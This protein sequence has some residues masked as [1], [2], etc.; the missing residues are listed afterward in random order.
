MTEISYG[1]G[2]P[3][4]N[5]GCVFYPTVYLTYTNDGL[6]P[7]YNDGVQYPF[8]SISNPKTINNNNG[9]NSYT[10]GEI[11]TGF[12][13]TGHADDIDLGSSAGLCYV[14]GRSGHGDL[15]TYSIPV[16]NA[17]IDDYIFI[18]GSFF[19]MIMAYILRSKYRSF[20]NS[21]LIFVST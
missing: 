18:L 12:S 6:S 7:E 4:A 9:S 15:R 16:C 13:S 8:Y 21:H 11:N 3:G 10:C 5:Q 14:T 2:N 19:S 20:I 17:P 1:A